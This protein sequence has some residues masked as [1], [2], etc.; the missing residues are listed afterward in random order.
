MKF[1][2]IPVDE[3]VGAVLAHSLKAGERSL[4]KGRI[5]S[6]EDVAA[7]KTAGRRSIVAARIEPSDVDENTAAAALAAPLAGHHVS[8]AQ[9][10]TGRVNLLAQRPELGSPPRP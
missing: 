1:G 2:E 10:F 7:L 9:P 5:L 6:A 4:R 3:A 8:A